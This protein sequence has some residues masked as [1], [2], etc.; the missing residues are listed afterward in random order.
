MVLCWDQAKPVF[1]DGSLFTLQE[2]TKNNPSFFPTRDTMLSDPQ[3]YSLLTYFVILSHFV[4]ITVS[5]FITFQARLTN[6]STR[7]VIIFILY[8]CKTEVQT[9]RVALA[10]LRAQGVGRQDL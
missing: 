3:N 5:H 7:Q 4:I 8:R 6:Y 2:V 9:G 10:K 1:L